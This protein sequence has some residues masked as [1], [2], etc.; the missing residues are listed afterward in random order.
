M[1]KDK[2]RAK[3]QYKKQYNDASFYKLSQ[4]GLILKSDFLNQ[5]KNL[6]NLGEALKSKKELLFSLD[7]FGLYN[8]E[9]FLNQRAKA[10]ETKR[11]NLIDFKRLWTS[12]NLKNKKEVKKKTLFLKKTSFNF[13]SNLLLKKRAFYFQI[14]KFFLKNQKINNLEFLSFLFL[15]RKVNRKLVSETFFKKEVEVGFESVYLDSKSLNPLKK[16]NSVE[17]VFG[18]NQNYYYIQFYTNKFFLDY[19]FFYI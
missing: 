6:E 14:S 10:V 8:K 15:I 7:F 9:S 12:K 11:S 1:L 2:N 3:W 19:P 4:K 16:L 5:E 13:N 18:L 17:K